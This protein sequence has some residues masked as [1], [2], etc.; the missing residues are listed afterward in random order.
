[1]TVYKWKV[2]RAKLTLQIF[3][4]SHISFFPCASKTK[5]TKYTTNSQ[6]N[7]QSHIRKI[8]LNHLLCYLK[9]LIY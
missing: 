3:P 7:Q 9:Q 2:I 1:M 6:K 4:I 5:K 8:L